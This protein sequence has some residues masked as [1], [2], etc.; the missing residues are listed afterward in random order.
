MNAEFEVSIDN[1]RFEDGR[2]AL[3]LTIRNE[4][5]EANVWLT[6]DEARDLRPVLTL[7]DD[8]RALR[9][10]QCADARAHWGRDAEKHFYLLIGQ[11][12]ETWD[13]GITLS[14]SMFAAIVGRIDSH[15]ST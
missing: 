8:S 12:D 4:T 5:I 3:L 1:A 6:V 2:A 11:D 14:E 10:G 15:S 7:P 13:V 9:L